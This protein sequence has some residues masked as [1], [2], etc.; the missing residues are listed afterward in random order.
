MYSTVQCTQEWSV[1]QKVW[2]AQHTTYAAIAYQICK[3]HYY[4]KY[5]VLENFVI[6]FNTNFYFIIF[7]NYWH[8]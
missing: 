5:D 2:G 4:T 7:Q 8:L 1:D 3:D 6:K